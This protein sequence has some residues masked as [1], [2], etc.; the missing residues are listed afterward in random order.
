M[1]VCLELSNLIFLF[2]VSLRSVLGL[3]EL[4]EPGILRLGNFLLS[5]R[6]KV[7]P[8]IPCLNPN[9][10]Y[11]LECL[12]YQFWFFVC[13][14]CIFLLSIVSGAVVVCGPHNKPIGARQFENLEHDGR[15]FGSFKQTIIFLFASNSV[16][17]DKFAGNG[18]EMRVIVEL[19]WSGGLNL[20]HCLYIVAYFPWEIWKQ[21]IAVCNICHLMK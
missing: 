4:T 3:S 14:Q 15:E 6:W 9:P 1:K 21:M 8:M 2:Q 11:Y 13:T 12:D 5:E 19:R 16:L 18:L 7:Y 17:W 20:F 10:I